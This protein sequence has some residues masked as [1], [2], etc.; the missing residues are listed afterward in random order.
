MVTA[1]SRF[2]SVAEVAVVLCA[3]PAAA[4]TGRISGMVRDAGGVALS[5]AT[6]A[7]RNQA[8]GASKRTTSTADGRFTVSDLAPGG[9]TVSASMPGVR[10]LRKDVQV[11]AGA[12]RPPARLLAA[13][14]RWAGAAHARLR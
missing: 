4:Q 11:T 10:A 8:T 9:Y 6:V 3:V 2:L 5:G 7:V 14:T 12:S 13:G 1:G